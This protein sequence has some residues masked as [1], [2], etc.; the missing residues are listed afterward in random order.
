MPREISRPPTGSIVACA[1]ALVAFA[2]PTFAQIPPRINVSGA[3]S[4]MVDPRYP[5]DPQPLLHGWTVSITRNITPVLG[6]T[7][8][9]GGNYEAIR[10]YRFGGLV[11]VT[12]KYHAL[13]AGP[14]VA[15]WKNARV[16]PYAHL[17]AGL[18]FDIVEGND[19]PPAFALE[20]GG[21]IDFW[22]RPRIGIGV[23]GGYRRL[24]TGDERIEH[25][26]VQVGVVLT[27]AR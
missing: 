3:Y 27:S 1:V 12:R 5:L 4:V 18:V 7:G 11:T 20:P 26:R 13:L 14:R 8:E 10:I 25:V 15:S 9:L 21:G 2:T 23:G 22:I 19:A 17:L 6:L 24:F 16:T